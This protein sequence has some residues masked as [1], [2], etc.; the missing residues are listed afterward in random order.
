MSTFPSSP[1]TPDLNK[2]RDWQ[3]RL[4]VAGS[5]VSMV[6]LVA[7]IFA[8]IKCLKKTESAIPAAQTESA[9]IASNE[10]VGNSTRSEGPNPSSELFVL[11][12]QD[13]LHSPVSLRMV[14]KCFLSGQPFAL[15]YRKLDFVA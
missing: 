3:K 6:T 1:S 12:P 11:N 8:I 10:I 7:F 2:Y 5:I 14:S 15:F 4:E 13:D 9:Q